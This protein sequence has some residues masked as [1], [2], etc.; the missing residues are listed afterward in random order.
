MSRILAIRPE[1]GL[2]ATRALG[3]EMG[4]TITG[5]PL[6]EIRAVAW[7]CP[8]PAAIDALL[9]GSANA[10]IHGGEGLA[11]LI[12]KPIHAVGESTAAAARA[13]GFGLAAIGSGGLQGVLDAIA[14]PSRLLRIAGAEHVPLTARE[15]IGIETVIAYESVAIALPEPLIA[16]LTD[17]PLVLLHSAAAAAHFASECERL[18]LDRGDIALAALGPRIAAAVGAGWRAIHIAPRPRDRDLLEMVCNLCD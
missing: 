1:P 12:D 18:A 11:R 10:I 8:D 9:I 5:A 15:G 16:A 7:D 4:L 17:A 3:R 14:P 6:F 13:A 2:T